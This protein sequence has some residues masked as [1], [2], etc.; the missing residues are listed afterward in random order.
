MTDGEKSIAQVD[1]S[2][3]LVGNEEDVLTA[4]VDSHGRDGVGDCFGETKTQCRHP[5]LHVDNVNV[6]WVGPKIETSRIIQF[7][8]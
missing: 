6:V 4:A 3:S 5:V 7:G 1:Y 2:Q 8:I